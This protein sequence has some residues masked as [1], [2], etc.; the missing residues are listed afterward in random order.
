MNYIISA[1]TYIFDIFIIST[2]LKS[3]LKKFKSKYYVW[4]AA[5]LVSVEIILYIN[6]WLSARYS[7]IPSA[8]TTPVISIL[9]TFGLC[10]FFSNTIKARILTTLSFQVLVS[11]GE[12]FFTFIITHINPAI[13]QITDRVLLYSIMNLGSKVML[14][15]LCMIVALFF[16][17]A[18]YEH[19]V[20]YSVLLFT[21]P[22]ITVT[23]FSFTPLHFLSESNNLLFYE[24]LFVCLTLL[25]IVNY[26]LI[27]KTF[28]ATIIKYTNMNIQ[29]QLDFQ[30]KKYEQLGES[31]RQTRRIIHDVKKHYFYIQE[32]IKKQHYDELLDYTSTAIQDMEDHYAKYNTGNLVIDSFLTS[33]DNLAVKNNI[34]FFARLNVDFNRIPVGDYDLCTILGNILDNCMTACRVCNNGDKYINM[35]IETTEDDRFTIHC[36]NRAPEEVP[37]KSR[38]SINHGFGMNNIQQAV[39][40][41]HGYYVFKHSGDIFYTDIMV[42]II[43]ESK[44]LYNGHTLKKSNNIIS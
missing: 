39:E 29:R 23:I 33:Y 44:R 4:Y 25:N 40:K 24:I 26:V 10:F 34:T 27:Q 42:P 35:I 17:N 18:K 12:T 9:T 6:E 7:F 21:T 32:Q 30:K 16:R 41:Y 36:E 11:L 3:M 14:F 31:Y 1:I 43:D 37:K 19:P 15:L 38:R 22:V 8:L 20:E 2:Y 13:L 28:A 5:S